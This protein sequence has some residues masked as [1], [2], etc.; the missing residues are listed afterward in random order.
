MIRL[1][2]KVM[3]LNLFLCQTLISQTIADFEIYN[4]EPDTFV[5]GSDGSG[6]FNSGSI[7]LPNSYDTEFG[8]WSGWSISTMRDDSTPGFINQYSAITGSG[9]DSTDHY[10]VSFSSKPN[11][12]RM[13]PTRQNV[14]GMYVTNS[15]YAFLSM[16]DGDAFAKKFGGA[17]GTDPDYFL[18]TIKYYRDGQ[19]STDSLDFYLA[20]FR[21]EDS[22]EDYLVNQWEFVDLSAF[23]EVDSLWLSLSSSDVGQFGMNTP[24]YFCMDQ[25][26]TEGQSTAVHDPNKLLI[27]I[28]PNPAYEAVH[29]EGV[30]DESISF[31]I[32]NLAGQIMQQGK[33]GSDHMIR[34]S[35]LNPGTYHLHFRSNGTQLIKSLIKR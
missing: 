8:F 12:V 22:K 20:D 4:L 19:L 25:F 6:G 10:A 21:F 30:S 32:F 34:L 28:F 18:L 13:A 14:H 2:T 31:T 35:S 26:V 3:L 7:F 1:I 23:G 11:I 16:R 9:A 29:I 33:T 17:N 27:Q 24:A 5:N 15:T